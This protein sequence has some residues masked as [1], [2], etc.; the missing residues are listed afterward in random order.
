MPRVQVS[1]G[2]LL[3]KYSILEIKLVELS[4]SD[5]VAFVK[6]EKAELAKYAESLLGDPEIQ[7]LYRELLKINRKI[8]QDMEQVYEAQEAS[9][10]VP[11]S[12]VVD[13][14]EDNK[15]RARLK[16][17]IDQVTESSTREAKSYF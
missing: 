6:D 11:Y 8:W 14:I 9:G 10:E 7:R 2:E 5:Q 3:D 1:N 4:T 13:I 16:R 15:T 17:Q 12:L